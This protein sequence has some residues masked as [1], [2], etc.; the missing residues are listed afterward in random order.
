MFYAASWLPRKTYADCQ[1]GLIILVRNIV[2]RNI[3]TAER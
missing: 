2:E 3:R 1:P